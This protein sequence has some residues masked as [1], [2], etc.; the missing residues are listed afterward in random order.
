MK[1]I[2][3]H[4][5]PETDISYSANRAPSPCATKGQGS[6]GKWGS[7]QNIQA[8]GIQDSSNLIHR[9]TLA[10][11]ACLAVGCTSGTLN[12][13][14]DVAAAGPG[15]PAVIM[16]QLKSASDSLNARKAQREINDRQFRRLMSNIAKDYI[17]QAEDTTITDENASAWGQV[18][19]SARDWK[20]AEPA[21]LRAVELQRNVSV[22]DFQGLGQW[23]GN[24]LALASTQAHLGKVTEAIATT[25][26]VF[27]VTPKAKAPILTS[28]LYDVVPAG[29]RQGADVQLA[30]LLKDAI[31]Q[32]QQVL[33]DPS[34]DGGRSFLAARPHHIRRAWE[35]IA[36]LYASAG[37]REMAQE[38]LD[39]SH[40]V[41]S[42]SK[43]SQ[44]LP[45]L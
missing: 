15:T 14:N 29:F 37:E 8:I 17:A 2:V 38:A 5:S 23:V 34:T 3:T 35:E 21:L 41:T 18:Y 30:E 33:V 32:H 16:K 13:P 40:R 45:E 10:I 6:K 43:S 4:F 42:A 27:K 28:V 11:V 12:D 7:G 20:A 39:E 22:A 9:F 1:F 19:M 26:S 36:L 31:K 24:S 25:R 44:K